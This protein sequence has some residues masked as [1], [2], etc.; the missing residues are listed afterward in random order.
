MAV[1]LRAYAKKLAAIS[2]QVESARMRDEVAEAVSQY[3]TLVC[4]KNLTK[5][6]WVSQML[7]NDSLPLAFTADVLVQM[8]LDDDSPNKLTT[9]D[10]GALVVENMAKE[11][12]K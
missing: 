5:V 4:A 11:S 8:A 3:L 6:G 10:V 9:A 2:G 12:S 7:A 1:V